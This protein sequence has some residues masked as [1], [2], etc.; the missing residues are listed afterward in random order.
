MGWAYNDLATGFSRALAIILTS[1]VFL[2]ICSFANDV[3]AL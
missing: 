2:A 3:L 1:I